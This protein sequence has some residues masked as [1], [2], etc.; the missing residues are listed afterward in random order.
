MNIFKIQNYL[1]EKIQKNII[2]MFK[3]Q[4][5]NKLISKKKKKLLILKNKNFFFSPK[6]IANKIE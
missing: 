3:Y 4:F 6:R 5:K 2:F 1:K